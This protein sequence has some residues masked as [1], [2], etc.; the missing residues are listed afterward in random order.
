M[1][2][3][4]GRE[5]HTAIRIGGVLQE[6]HEITRNEI[7]GGTSARENTDGKGLQ[8]NWQPRYDR[9][10]ALDKSTESH[11]RTCANTLTAREDRG[12]SNQ[13][14]TGTAIAIPIRGINDGG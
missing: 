11:V 12:V 13:K 7:G 2:R 14:Q 6:P 4:G 10:F 9:C 5:P 1:C 8:G 3:W